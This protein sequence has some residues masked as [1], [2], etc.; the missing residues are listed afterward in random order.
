MIF[1][2]SNTFSVS[3]SRNVVIYNSLGWKRQEL[4]SFRVTS[5]YIEV[6][7]NDGNT[8]LSQINPVWSKNSISKQEYD[9]SS[10]HYFVIFKICHVYNCFLFQ[11]YFIA[12]IPALGLVSYKV[13]LLS[14]N[15]G[16][17]RANSFAS[18]TYYNEEPETVPRYVTLIFY[19]FDLMSM[20]MRVTSLRY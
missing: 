13:K 6:C 8:L 9:V 11:V 3:I 17:N 20:K 15:E 14:L 16:I 7:D 19:I 12:K 18:L 5:P 1:I 4:V 10:L 2:A